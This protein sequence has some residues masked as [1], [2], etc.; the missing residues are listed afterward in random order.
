MIVLR[1]I[2]PDIKSKGIEEG[3]SIPE[4]ILAKLMVFQKDFVEALKVVR[5]SAMREV[6]VETPDV[7]WDDIG[8][9]TQIKDQLKEAVEWPL[10]RPEAFKRLG[11]R[12]PRGVLL[13]GPPGTGKT[14]LAKA[15][16]KESEANFIL[17]NGPS[18]LSKWVGESEK[19]LRK[20]F[21]KARQTSP[22]ILFFDEIDSL[23]PR[24][25]GS[26]ND[27]GVSERLVNQMLT[28]MD[29]LESLHDVVVIAA[30]NRPDMVDPALLRQ[31][32]FDRIILT[33]V[34]DEKG[35]KNIFNIYLKKMTILG[36][37]DDDEEKNRDLYAEKLA[38]ETKGYVGADIEGVCREGA[39]IALREDAK[40][41]EVKME[42]F[43]AA[44]D[45][46]KPSVNKEVEEAYE[47]LADYFSAA[48]AKE[49]TEEKT[50]YVG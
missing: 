50:S 13:Y 35:R 36:Q 30:T 39:M 32:R 43:K 9:L 4:E 7:N 26:S 11:I 14:L 29:G 34:P 19:A 40:A 33:P 5:P 38:K 1:R 27:A 41:K 49:I 31:G 12:P 23:V 6:L 45:V 17:I 47:N 20:I 3:D 48:R 28:E 24:R 15:V 22:T 46:V 37:F 10:K 25:T 8:G 21:A 18:L 44:L 2:L 42:H 16:A